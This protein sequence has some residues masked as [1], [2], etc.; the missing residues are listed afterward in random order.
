MASYPLKEI[1]SKY[2]LKDI[3]AHITKRKLYKIN[4]Y[5]KSFQEKLSIDIND[6]K[7]YYNQIEIEIIPKQNKREERNYFINI[8]EQHKQYYHIYFNDDNKEKNQNYFNK[9]NYN[10]K[11]KNNNR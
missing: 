1:K 7:L 4:N 5:N 2:I 6:Y 3:F 9:D 11:N 10:R 8:P